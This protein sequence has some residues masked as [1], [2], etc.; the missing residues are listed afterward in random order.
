V[1][2]FFDQ[3]TGPVVDFMREHSAWAALFAFI[4]AFL[5]SLAVVSLFV[6]ATVMLFGLG[7]L[8]A[9][10]AV[11]IWEILMAA[12]AG[13]ILGNA[14]SYWV[15]R[16]YK[17]SIAGSWLF[18]KRPELLKKGHDFF[19]QHGGKSVFI[20]RFFGPTRAV[21]PLVA[22]MIEMPRRRFQTA[23][24][25]SAVVWVIISIAPGFAPSAFPWSPNTPAQA[26]RAAP[27]DTG[28]PSVPL[29]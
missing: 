26:T 7:A 10:G 2:P 18:R 14:V 11:G 20:G 9:A 29:R 1:F 28:V 3:L 15:G 23:N 19:E 21:V 12:L 17:H 4:I 16:R 8:A 6:P 24:V 13:A 27:A 5:E 25:L 22:G